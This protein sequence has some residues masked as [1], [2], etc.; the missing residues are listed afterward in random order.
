[1]CHL[2]GILTCATQPATRPC[3]RPCGAY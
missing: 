3:V 2:G 1:M